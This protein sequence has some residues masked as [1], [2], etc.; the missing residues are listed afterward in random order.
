MAAI[1]N[2]VRRG[3]EFAESQGKTLTW[4]QALYV[5]TCLGFT[6]QYDLDL[7]N[8]SS[9]EVRQGITDRFPS[10]F[11][12]AH[13]VGFR[14]WILARKGLNFDEISDRAEEMYYQNLYFAEIRDWDWDGIKSEIEEYG[15]SFVGSVMWLTPSGCFYTPWANSSVTEDEAE[16][17]EMWWEALESIANEHGFSAGCGENDPCDIFIFGENYDNGL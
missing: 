17:D 3:V 5:G 9:Q 14:Y 13:E 6:R 16:L 4:Q 15:S 2:L 8:L 12:M 10:F 11:Q 1:K 7:G